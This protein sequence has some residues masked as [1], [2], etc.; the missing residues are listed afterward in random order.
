MNEGESA[1]SNGMGSLTGNVL[2][3]SCTFYK[4]YVIT[5]FIVCRLHAV[6]IDGESLIYVPKFLGED[7]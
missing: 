2:P 1:G 4:A 3:K 6:K 7:V 5:I